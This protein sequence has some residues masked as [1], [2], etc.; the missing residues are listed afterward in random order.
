MSRL[1]VDSTTLSKLRGLSGPVE[2]CDEQ[3]RIV[4]HFVHYTGPLISTAPELEIS[5]EEL[6]RRAANFHGRPLDE[7]VAQWERR[8]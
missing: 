6:D 2:L 4:G 7:L 1:T 8:K 3:G 5:E